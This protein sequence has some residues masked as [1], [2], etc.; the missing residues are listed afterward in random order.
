MSISKIRR[1]WARHWEIRQNEVSKVRV[2]QV[3][4]VGEGGRREGW[5]YPRISSWD[6]R[7]EGYS[8]LTSI[9]REAQVQKVIFSH[10]SV[11]GKEKIQ[12]FSLFPALVELCFTVLPTIIEW[13][14]G[15]SGWFEIQSPGFQFMLTPPLTSWLASA[16]SSSAKRQFKKKPCVL[17]RIIIWLE[18]KAYAQ[19][20]ALKT[21]KHYAN[22]WC[23]YDLVSC[24]HYD[25]GTRQDI[26]MYSRLCFSG[27]PSRR[28]HDHV[29]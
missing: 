11:P 25:W 27:T 8:V 18:D 20:K 28:E 21:A 22:V 26:P 4:R 7:W 12:R 10:R 17:H 13:T 19:S 2:H 9:S 15:V 24:M 23:Y 29:E 1:C 3:L 16:A 5:D 6:C 14:C